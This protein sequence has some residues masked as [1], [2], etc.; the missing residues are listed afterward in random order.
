MKTLVITGL[1]GLGDWSK[2][3]DF[4][5]NECKW[6][7]IEQPLQVQL[8]CKLPQLVQ[9]LHEFSEMIALSNTIAP[10]EILH[11]NTII[12]KTPKMLNEG[13]VGTQVIREPS[14]MDEK[15]HLK[16]FDSGTHYY[17]KIN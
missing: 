7:R 9:I 13:I 11:G 1:E 17:L 8:D 12:W 2:L 16:T 10:I 4:L 14:N 5:E 3:A 15:N 6:N